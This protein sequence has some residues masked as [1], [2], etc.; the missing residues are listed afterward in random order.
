MQIYRGT[1]FLFEMSWHKLRCKSKSGETSVLSKGSCLRFH[2]R[3]GEGTHTTISFLSVYMTTS[4]LYCGYSSYSYFHYN[5]FIFLGCFCFLLSLVSATT[6]AGSSGSLQDAS[7][8][9]QNFCFNALKPASSVFH[10]I[11]DKGFIKGLHE[12]MKI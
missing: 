11:L 8:G 6:W 7:Q 1:P 5:T 4:L 2:V 3:S 9:E 12:C 10:L